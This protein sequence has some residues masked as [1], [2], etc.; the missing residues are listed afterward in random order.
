MKTKKSKEE[1]KMTVSKTVLV[2]GGQAGL[3]VQPYKSLY[4]KRLARHWCRP[5]NELCEEFF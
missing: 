2:T 1:K 5:Q 4:R 3:A